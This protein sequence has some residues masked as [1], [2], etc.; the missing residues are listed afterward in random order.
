LLACSSGANA[1][2]PDAGA[3]GG[4]PAG[5]GCDLDAGACAPAAAEGARCGPDAEP[6][7]P[8]LCEDGLTCGF[9]AG[10]SNLCTRACV[11]AS[12]C[13]AGQSCYQATQDGGAR[14]YR[15]TPVAVGGHCG[16]DELLQCASTAGAVAGCILGADG[17]GTCLQR[18]S[19]AAPCPDGQACSGAFSDGQG[20]C[21]EPTQPGS[22]CEQAALRFCTE[23][24][25]CVVEA[26][27]RGVCHTACDPSGAPGCASTEVCIRADPCEPTGQGFCVAPQPV[28]GGCAPADDHF[29]GPGAV[30]VNFN[31]H[32][33]VCKPDCTSGQACTDG[34]CQALPSGDGASCLSACF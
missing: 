29:C 18:C 21:G 27:T 24:Q 11:G 20:V 8:T 34:S 5:Q 7:T 19:S 25:V 22:V 14:R 15:A 31:N 9:V 12:D 23:G 13:A 3:C 4:C 6:G 16:P 30:C 33:L 26:G 17:G 2:N 10:G 28:D 32:D 1:P